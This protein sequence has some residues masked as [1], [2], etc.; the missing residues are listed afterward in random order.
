METLK[1]YLARLGLSKDSEPQA[2]ANAKT[3][4]TRW[5]KR[6][7]KR[8]YRKERCYVELVLTPKEKQVLVTGAKNH[9]KPLAT[10]IR[11][12]ALA[13]Q[14]RLYI[15][16]DPSQLHQLEMA[17]R[18]IG[19]NINQIAYQCNAQ[20]NTR[21]QNVVALQQRVTDL[22]RSVTRHLVEPMTMERLIKIEL[23]KH[24]ELFPIVQRMLYKKGLG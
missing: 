20:G 10:Y 17:F 7:K 5:Y 19:N 13:Y 23:P 24:P 21:Y 12:I 9:K 2:L 11:E 22:E 18:R 1:D 6:E 4:Y 8:Q 14:R 16:P 3:D 15:L